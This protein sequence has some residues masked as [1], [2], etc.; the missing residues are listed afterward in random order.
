MQKKW[1]SREKALAADESTGTGKKT[2]SVNVEC[3]E[4]NRLHFRD[5][6]FIASMKTNISGV[7]LLMK[8]VDKLQIVESQ[9]QN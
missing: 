8:H 6:I 1:W 3:T 4:K 9:F 7:I 2:K 5:F